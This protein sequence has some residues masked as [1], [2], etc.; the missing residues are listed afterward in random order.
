VL[1]LSRR[2]FRRREHGGRKIERQS[3]RHVGR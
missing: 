1:A 3:D 2:R